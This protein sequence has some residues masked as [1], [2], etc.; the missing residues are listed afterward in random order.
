MKEPLCQCKECDTV[1]RAGANNPE[2][3][4]CLATILSS[5]LLLWTEVLPHF[6]DAGFG[7]VTDSGQ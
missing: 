6:M 2:L 5:S 3:D 4:Y 1:C 7:P